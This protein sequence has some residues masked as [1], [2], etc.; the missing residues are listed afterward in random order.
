M[1]EDKKA[2][3]VVLLYAVQWDSPE[4]AKRYF[5]A[6]RK[7]LQKKW[8][9]MDVAS[10]TAAAVTGTGDDGHFE[11]RLDGPVVTSMEGLPPTID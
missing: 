9:K 4:I 6:Y 5:E 1:R 11:L 2:A 3:R 8:K 7:V 10:E